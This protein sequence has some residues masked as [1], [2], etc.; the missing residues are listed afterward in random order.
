MAKMEAQIANL[1]AWVQTA[2]SRPNSA[3]SDRISEMSYTSTRSSKSVHI[4]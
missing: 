1:T 2:L 4:A 3:A